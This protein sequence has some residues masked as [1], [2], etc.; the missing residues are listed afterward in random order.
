MEKPA[1]R[2]EIGRTVAAFALAIPVGFAVFVAL[3]H[4]QLFAGLDIVFYRGLV[5][6]AIAGLLT[7]LLL[8]AMRSVL[9]ISAATV[10]SAAVLSMSLNLTFLIVLPVTIDRSVTV[11][12]L[13]EMDHHPDTAFTNPQLRAIFIERYLD[14][15]DQIDRRMREQILSHNIERSGD[16]YKISPQGRAF[17]R[18]SRLLAAIFGTDPRF[19]GGTSKPAAP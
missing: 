3:F 2:G 13:S 15:W 19:V 10:L 11:F 18:L 17:M 4:L 5:L 6:L 12:L 16:G 9:G 7:G 14:Q 8:W 1:P